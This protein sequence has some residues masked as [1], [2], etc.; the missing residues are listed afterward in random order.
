M[1]E[2]TPVS[3]ESTLSDDQHPASGWATAT[4]AIQYPHPDGS[5]DKAQATLRL[6]SQNPAKAAPAQTRLFG[7]DLL[8]ARSLTPPADSPEA[9]ASGAPPA[10]PDD[11][12]WVLDFP[13]QQLDLLLVDLA[14]NGFFAAQMRN[15]PGTHLDVQIDRGRT[16]KAWTPEPRLDHFVAR[17]YREGRLGG[18]VPCQQSPNG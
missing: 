4:L 8:A 14:G 3:F 1:A 15:D 16:E 13:K 6:S 12:I 17:V 2:I 5:T 18:F 7:F 9:V 11:E 10:S